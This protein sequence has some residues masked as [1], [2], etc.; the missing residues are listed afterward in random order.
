MMRLVGMAAVAGA[1]CATAACGDADSADQDSKQVIATEDCPE[2]PQGAYVLR[3]ALASGTSDCP[4]LADEV[5]VRRSDGGFTTQN[6]TATA[7]SSC[8]DT[9]TVDGCDRTLERSCFF[10]ADQ[11]SAEVVIFLD[12]TWSGVMS[13][14]VSCGDGSAVTCS[15]DTWVEAR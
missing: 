14:Q 1:L 9:A 11:C 12:E 4:E 8:T 10:T 3:K 15:Y 7:D 2:L 5:F 13:L 6:Q